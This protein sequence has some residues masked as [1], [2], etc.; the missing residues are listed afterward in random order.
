M[1][2][3]EMGCVFD[4]LIPA[5]PEHADSPFT[6]RDRVW[7]LCHLLASGKDLASVA[8]KANC[9]PG[10]ICKIL[11]EDL[12]AISIAATAQWIPGPASQADRCVFP[13]FATCVCAVDTTP[14]KFLDKWKASNY[15]AHAFYSVKYGHTCAKAQLCVAPNGICVDVAVLRPG[16]MNDVRI[17]HESGLGDRFQYLAVENG[18]YRWARY[19]FIADSGYRGASS[20]WSTAVVKYVKPAHGQ[21]LEWQKVDNAKLD[22]ARSVV[23]RFNGLFKKHWALL[24][25]ARGLYRLS[26][27][28]L[29]SFVQLAVALTNFLQEYRGHA[30]AAT[31]LPAGV[32]VVRLVPKALT[33]APP[34]TVVQSAPPAPTHPEDGLSGITLEN[35]E[36]FYQQRWLNQPRARRGRRDD[37]HAVPDQLPNLY[38]DRGLPVPALIDNPHLPFP[39]EQDDDEV[40]PPRSRET[41]PSATPAP[42][43]PPEPVGPDERRQLDGLPPRARRR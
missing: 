12:E 38:V 21:L 18:Q 3:T 19:G 29:Q 8:E 10:M 26:L 31:G 36:D 41:T 17:L 25:G 35:W 43:A 23:E 13:A 27:R 2:Q 9:T 7:L 40:V 5:V 39:G 32:D 33:H 16:R 15:A 6:P 4:V 30:A 28:H 37:G 11:Q 20:Y 22:S 1:N 42:T 24:S 34:G 14:I